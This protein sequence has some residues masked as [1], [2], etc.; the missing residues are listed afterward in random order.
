[1]A[2]AHAGKIY[3]PSPPVGALVFPRTEGHTAVPVPVPLPAPWDTVVDC[4]S[5]SDSMSTSDFNTL[6]H[7]LR[8]RALRD[9][10]KGARIV[11]SAGCSGRWYF[12]WIAAA[13]AGIECHIGVE[14]YS[15]RPD[16]LP[17][18]VRWIA[19]SVAD[20]TGVADGSVDL[21][22]SGQ[23]IEH[24]SPPDIVGFLC[25]AKR[26]LKPD[27]ILAIDSPNRRITAMLGWMQ[28]EHVVEM[29]VDEIV[30]L[31]ETAGFDIEAVRGLWQC[32]DPIRHRLLP[33]EPSA[34][35]G[36]NSTRIAAA[37]DDPENAFAWW[38]VARSS[39]TRATNR[40]AL[41]RHVT[42]I[43][44]VAFAGLAKRFH[45]QVG[46][47]VHEPLC[48]RAR[49]GAGTEGFLVYGPYVVVFPGSYRACY[50]LRMTDGETKSTDRTDVIAAKI[51][52][53][54][55]RHGTL[56]NEIASREILA[57]EIRTDGPT[58][59]ATVTLPLELSDT[60]FGVEFRVYSTGKVGLEVALP[61]ELVRR[62]GRA[63]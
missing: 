53:T 14:A 10:P 8:T 31:C 52:V 11:L 44:S 60:A 61:V 36:V 13:Y 58:D 16:D 21:V 59:F 50:R 24:L 38:L 35:D 30:G 56:G 17:P 39:R 33:L 26:V 7:D 1:M 40:S 28:P 12:D 46:E 49:A 20:M 18:G 63:S 6:L 23:N 19:A 37:R 41:E 57:I 45:T 9:L 62:Q 4:R 25:E 47:L 5:L 29:R 27:G 51:D 54:V 48:D 22:F 15:P 34:D 55:Y 2:T 3:H 42:S 32:Y 43:A